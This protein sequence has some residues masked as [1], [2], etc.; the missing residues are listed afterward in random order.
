MINGNN[1]IK[2]ICNPD[3]EEMFELIR[4]AHVNILVTFQATGLKL[5]LL[6]VLYQG[7]FC[8]VNDKMLNGTGLDELC[9]IGNDVPA[10]KSQLKNL[11]GSEF[12]EDDFSRREKLLNELYSNSKNAE[13]LVELVWG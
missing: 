9:I 5:K 3:D 4:T 8:L 13:R 12:T 1:N 11:F 2:L 7:R 6:N 10:L